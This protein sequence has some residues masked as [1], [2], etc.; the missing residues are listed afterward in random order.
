MF[1]FAWVN[2][3]DTTFGPEHHV[4]D[5]V[6]F[7]AKLSHQ[8]GDIPTLTLVIKNPRV[9][10]LNP[11]RKQWA[12]ASWKK[13]DNT[14][15]PIL[16]GRL[17]G[18]PADLEAEFITIVLVARPA[19]FEQQKIELAETLK[20]PPYY[21]P[22]FLNE[23]KLDD[24]EIVLEARPQLWHVGRTDKVVSVSHINDAEDG[25]I[26]LD[27]SEF[28]Y[29]GLAIKIGSDPVRK[30]NVSATVKWN[31]NWRATIN[32]T[33]NL[34]RAFNE[35]SGYGS[36]SSIFAQPNISSYTGQGLE[37]AWPLPGDTIGGGWSVKVSRLTLLSGDSITPTFEEFKTIPSEE[38]NGGEGL[39]IRFYLWVFGVDLQVEYVASRSFTEVLT[40][41]LDADIQQILVDAEP[42][43]ET[44]NL[45][46][47]NVSLEIDEP[48]A[49]GGGTM[50]IV[51]LRR[52][53]YFNTDR[54]RRTLK[55]LMM[56]TRTKVMFSARCVQV[57]FR[58]PFETALNF[59]CRKK[60]IL[61]DDRLPGGEVIGKIVGYVLSMTDGALQASA[62]IACSVGN[63]GSASYD[64]GNNDHHDDYS[65][66]YQ[67]TSGAV[68][69]PGTGDISYDEYDIE[70]QDDGLDFFST[71]PRDFL[72]GLD[73]LGGPVEQIAALRER[74]TEITVINTD[75]DTAT[76]FDEVQTA[77][78][79]L[80]DHHTIVQLNLTP[81]TGGPFSTNFPITVSDLKVAKTIDL[82]A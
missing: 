12:W 20:V 66:D 60:I 22:V 47:T 1:Y 10:L 57:S 50:P 39:G 32:L 73:V 65:D 2:D 33:S 21:D 27:D 25:N 69:D 56:L 7:G 8:E 68:L 77:I 38:I 70:P 81:T 49:T 35:V 37:A 82:G 26:T 13:N 67:F 76:G 72:L 5:E 64:P 16:H 46:S 23:D 45:A 42:K 75:G 51:D 18:V 53:S 41:S 62:T 40:F 6:I 61:Q 79:L 24:P 14:V 48:E 30:V 55:W 9:G 59:S 19:D 15:V 31:Q 29:D 44:I 80:N 71:D 58:V 54:G 63:G 28:F 3:G 11:G 78:D 34:I 17:V 52:R 4:E 43:V 74:E 36:T